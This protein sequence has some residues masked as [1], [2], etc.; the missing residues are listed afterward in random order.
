MLNIRLFEM[1]VRKGFYEKLYLVIRPST[2]SPKLVGSFY[3][4]GDTTIK[5]YFETFN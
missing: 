2:T 1:R 4:N 5:T 3:L